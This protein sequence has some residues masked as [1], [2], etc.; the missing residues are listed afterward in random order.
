MPIERLVVVVVAGVPRRVGLGA[1]LADARA[2]GVD[3]VVHALAGVVLQ[4]RHRRVPAALGVVDDDLV[5]RGVAERA[6]DVALVRAARREPDRARDS[7]ACRVACA[8]IV[9]AAATGSSG[10]AAMRIVSPSRAGNAPP[11]R[12]IVEHA[13]RV[14]HARRASSMPD[15]CLERGAPARERAVARRSRA[16]LREHARAGRACRGRCRRAA[17]SSS[18]RELRA[19]RERVEPAVAQLEHAG[20]RHVVIGVERAQRRQPHAALLDRDRHHEIGRNIGLGCRGV[21]RPRD[22]ALRS[23]RARANEK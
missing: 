1:E 5:D 18:C 6:A 2:V 8:T 15:S 17:Q 4:R 3:D 21:D 14:A 23:L 16:E 11:V 9:R 22:R 13:A 10:C 7:R 19:E 20:D 12:R